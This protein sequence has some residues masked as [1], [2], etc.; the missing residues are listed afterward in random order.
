MLTARTKLSTLVICFCAIAILVNPITSVARLE[1]HSVLAEPNLTLIPIATLTPT[2]TPTPIKIGNFVWSDLDHD[3]RQDAD[4]PGLPGITVQLWNSAKN[5][6][7]DF[8][9][10][11]AN[12]NYQLT[13]PTPGNYRVRVVLPSILDQF[14]PKDLAGGSDIL[15]SDINPSGSDLGFTDIFN[16]ASNV[17]SISSIDAG[18]IKFVTPTPT[19]TPTPISV[20]NLI[21]ADDGDGVKESEELGLAG[22]T[23]QLWNSTKT[24]LIDSTVTNAN[25]L[26]TLIAPTP[27][28]YR[29]RVLLGIGSNFTAKD[30]GA[31]DLTDSDCNPIGVNQ[32]F[33]DVYNFASNLISISTIDCGL[34]GPYSTA[35]PTPTPTSTA[36]A[37]STMPPEPSTTPMISDKYVYLPIVL[38]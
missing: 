20:G 6:L 17:I 19:R 7:I 24:L 38:K 23:V 9:Q 16:I 34:T 15:D 25:G 12:G 36:S 28:N 13:A 14:S 29:V 5:M 1:T 27:G 3:G 8:T 33:T 31:N 21:W 30:I 4:E 22:V 10:T 26:Y 18:I 35:T 32:G 2:R 11:D 37:T